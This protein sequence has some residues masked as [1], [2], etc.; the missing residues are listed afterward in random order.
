[1]SRITNM[2]GFL[3]S[4]ITGGLAG[5]PGRKPTTCSGQNATC[6]YPPGK[7]RV[8]YSFHSFYQAAG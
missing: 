7:S 1:M 8:H 2:E 3:T 5:L 4:V 6:F